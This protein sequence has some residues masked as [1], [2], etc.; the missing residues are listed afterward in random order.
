MKKENERK[1]LRETD[2]IETKAEWNRTI[3][4]EEKKNSFNAD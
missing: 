3:Y 2:K 4:A 1:F